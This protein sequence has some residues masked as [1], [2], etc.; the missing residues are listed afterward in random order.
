MGSVFALLGDGQETFVR[1]M[2]VSHMQLSTRHALRAV[3]RDITMAGF[4]TPPASSILWTDGSG[5]TPDELTV[6]YADPDTPVSLP[7]QCGG[8]GQGGGGGP[9]GTIN[10]SST[11]LLDPETM[12]PK[13]ADPEY[14]YNDKMVLAAIET[15]D[16]NEDGQEDIYVR[17]TLTSLVS[18]RNVVSEM[19][20]QALQTR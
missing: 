13:P 1:E 10:Q 8:G 17:K 3:S 7:V 18:L 9:C 16:C 6:I 2:D 4:R 20:N 14:A 11:L 19:E 15:G 12:D 5:L